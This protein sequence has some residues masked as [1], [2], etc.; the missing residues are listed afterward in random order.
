MP[1]ATPIRVAKIAGRDRIQQWT[2]NFVQC[3]VVW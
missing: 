3:N 1:N 2:A